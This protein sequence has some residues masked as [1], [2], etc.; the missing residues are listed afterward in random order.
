M[1]LH[2]NPSF[3][4]P[5]WPARILI[6]GNFGMPVAMYGFT[7]YFLSLRRQQAWLPASVFFYGCLALLNLAGVVVTHSDV[8]EGLVTNQYGW[9]M[10]VAYVFWT[11]HF[12]P[13]VL[14]LLRELKRAKDPA[15]RT[16]L[17]YLLIVF[18]LMLAANLVNLSPLSAYPVDHLLA[19]FIAI[20]ISLSISR[21]QF[22]EVQRTISRLLTLVFVILLYIAIVT[23][24]L[25][26]LSTLNRQ[27][28]LPVSALAA[29][30]TA[31]LMLSYSPL[32]H[33]VTAF[34]DRVFFPQQYNLNG[35]IFA[36][37]EKSNRLR[38]P[39][40]LGDDILKELS[41]A[42]KF[43]SG[44]LLLKDN[45]N[46]EF[47]LVAS[48]GFDIPKDKVQ[49]PADSPLVLELSRLPCATHIDHLQELPRMQAL[50]I[51]EW[52]TLRLL[53]AQVLA[54]ITASGELIGCFV[55]G[56]RHGQEPY[57]RQELETTLPLLANQVSV[58]L[59]NCRLYT[60]E[61][62][63]ADQLAHVNRELRQAEARIQASLLEK[64]ALLK[65]IHHRVKNNLQIISSLLDL[66]SDRIQDRA[67]GLAFQDSRDRIR[68]MALIHE[69]LYR[70]EDL[71]QINAGEYVCELA[72]NLLAAHSKGNEPVNLELET[73]DIVLSVDAAVPCGLIINE[74]V[75]NALKYAFPPGWSA[76]RGGIHNRLSVSLTWV[77]AAERTD[78]PQRTRRDATIGLVVS[79]NG[80]GLPP[81]LS[82]D[83]A[84]S[85]G[86]Q[87]V[88][89]LS[90]QLGGS[91]E[92]DRSAGATFRVVFADRV[93]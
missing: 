90:Q 25:S 77:D 75:T 29:I 70:S 52:Q 17:G 93:D 26:Y 51:E 53:Q 91:V 33:G 47:R 27:A 12:Y 19:G 66:Q 1:L 32:R 30:L 89:L 23:V 24:A 39:S 41:R 6:L 8:S 73:D 88:S 74:L 43:E 45:T 87:L 35:L 10:Y 80:V 50:W 7:V 63:R 42:L 67:S 84:S 79:D 59:A 68:T 34:I 49:L 85:L 81:E 18:V 11:I 69:K 58:S 60:Q 65:E 44:C 72:H 4:D 48:I 5:I 62:A 64:E 13:S 20:F 92:V 82:P 16:R 57:S 46:Q 28:L 38:Q 36:I 9:G 15:F 14:L 31:G 71:A 40:D 22:R 3:I 55:F 83:N 78:G 21:R 37:S 76:G 86:L 61:Q 56:A 54:P 2:A